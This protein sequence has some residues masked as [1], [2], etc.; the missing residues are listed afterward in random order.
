MYDVHIQKDENNVYTSMT[1]QTI[2]KAVSDLENMYGVYF[3]RSSI[4][5]KKEDVIWTI[6]NCIREIEAV[7]V[8]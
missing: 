4:T 7:S 1:W 8:H 5:G 3:L 6:Y 2:P